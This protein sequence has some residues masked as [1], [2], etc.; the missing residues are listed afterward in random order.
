M[1]PYDGFFSRTRLGQR[2]EVKKNL[3]VSCNQLEKLSCQSVT[4]ERDLDDIFYCIRQNSE[5]LKCLEFADLDE[6]QSLEWMMLNWTQFTTAFKKCNKLEELRLDGL[7]FALKNWSL[8]R[9]DPHYNFIDLLK[10]LPQNLK[11]ISL[12]W[13]KIEELKVLVARCS[14]LEDLFIN[15]IC[16]CENSECPHFD[17]IISIIVGSSLSDTLVHLSLKMCWINVHDQFGA[18]CLELRQMK[19]LKKI[20]I[21]EMYGWVDLDK[22]EKFKDMLRKNLPHV[23]IVEDRQKENFLTPADPYAKHGKSSGLWEI[24]CNKLSL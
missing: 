2:L 13:L 19:A 11:K 22:E 15:G 23:T 18:K 17:E 1:G 21:N 16:C 24:S 5:S 9:F 10:C 4:S 7:I 12:G 3:L 8:F 20:E 14:K 6:V